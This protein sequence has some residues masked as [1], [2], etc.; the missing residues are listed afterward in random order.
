[1][2]Y[3]RKTD[4]LVEDIKGNVRNMKAKALTAFQSNSIE[5]GVP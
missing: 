2:A 4:T 1:M 5:Y 3:V